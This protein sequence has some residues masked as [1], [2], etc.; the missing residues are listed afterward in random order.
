[1]WSVILDVNR[2]G[3]NSLVVSASQ[4]GMFPRRVSVNPHPYL[5]RSLSRVPKDRVDGPYPLL[6]MNGNRHGALV[7]EA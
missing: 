7:V 6:C 1:M 3:P 4:S 5:G 2:R